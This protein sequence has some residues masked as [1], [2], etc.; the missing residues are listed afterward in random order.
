MQAAV[1]LVE[2]LNR[3]MPYI[4]NLIR[5]EGFIPRRLRRNEGY[6]SRLQPPYEN[7]IPRR[8]RRGC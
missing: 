2:A 8:S 7:N 4:S 6:E 3:N 1:F 5:A